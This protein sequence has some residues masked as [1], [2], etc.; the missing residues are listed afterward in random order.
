MVTSASLSII[1]L[2][3]VLGLAAEVTEMGTCHL[4]LPSSLLPSPTNFACLRVST[5][6][7]PSCWLVT[8]MQG[9]PIC[10]VHVFMTLVTGRLLA[11]SSSAH[12]WGLRVFW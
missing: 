2:T 3:G 6:S 9:N 8:L 7:A 11:A 10:S 5:L 12:S 4:L 1:T